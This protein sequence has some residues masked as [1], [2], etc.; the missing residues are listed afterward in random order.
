MNIVKIKKKKMKLQSKRRERNGRSN[1]VIDEGAE[2]NRE[3]FLAFEITEKRIS[4]KAKRVIEI[5]A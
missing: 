5:Q 2:C 3:I 1:I 4:E